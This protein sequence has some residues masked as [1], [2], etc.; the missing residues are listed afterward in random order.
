MNFYFCLQSK[1]NQK[2]PIL[3]EDLKRIVGNMLPEYFPRYAEASC[4]N[5]LFYSGKFMRSSC[6]EIFADIS[7]LLFFIKGARS[8]TAAA[9][10]LRDFKNLQV[11]KVNDH[12]NIG[13]EV[14]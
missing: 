14:L 8:L 9:V 7:Y 12:F 6:F 3:L 2:P 10:E 13:V 4:F 1:E 11:M 5:F